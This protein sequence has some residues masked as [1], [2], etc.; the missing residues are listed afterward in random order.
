MEYSDNKNGLGLKLI[1]QDESFELPQQVFPL[2]RFDF[3]IA[4]K[5]SLS[6]VEGAMMLIDTPFDI[7]IL[8]PFL[9]IHGFDNYEDETAI[10]ERGDEAN[11]ILALEFG[12]T[13]LPHHRINLNLLLDQIQIGGETRSMPNAFAALL[14]YETSYVVDEFYI[15]GWIEAAYTMPAT[16]LNNKMDITDEGTEYNP[17]YDYIV[18]YPIWGYENGRYGDI[19]Y[20]G[21]KYGPD[22]IVIGLGLDFGDLQKFSISAGINYIMHGSYGLGYNYT[23]A[24]RGENED[25]VPYNEED[26]SKLPLSV[27]VEDAEHRIE[28]SI[29]T[30][31]TPIEGLSISAGL[32]VL[33]IWN[34]RLEKGQKLFDMQFYIGCAFD[35]VRM[36]VK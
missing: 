18:G 16:Y 28:A 21:Y 17:N 15:T 25:D 10:K 22:A 30:K 6:L 13:F 33:Q 26:V 2:H 20:V 19:D 12:Y 24:A 7:R 27:P 14:N 4:D 11:N 29:K 3:K 8:N 5:V 35:P 9:F 1:S 32:G 36:F 34:Y 31:I 23:V